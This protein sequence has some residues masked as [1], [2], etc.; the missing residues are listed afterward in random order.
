MKDRKEEL[1]KGVGVA[2]KNKDG[3]ITYIRDPYL[4]GMKWEG[5]YVDSKSFKTLPSHEKL[6]ALSIQYL[7][8][9]IVLCEKA[10][11][12]GTKLTWPQGS[13]VFYCLHL[14]TELFLKSCL[15]CRGVPSKK[16]NHEIADLLREYE[17]VVP[18]KS[19]HFTTPWQLS[20]SDINEALGV[21]VIK[22]I[23]CV[24][25]QLFRYSFD[26]IGTPSNGTQFFSPG[27]LYN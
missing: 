21:D 19:Y 26:K 24:P 13:V 8:S 20:A 27:Y 18:E 7:R 11:E 17:K 10:G 9:A 25:D 2:I 23:D 4:D 15:L 1:P 6:Y 12:A 14:S 3:S 16:L 5:V 22:G